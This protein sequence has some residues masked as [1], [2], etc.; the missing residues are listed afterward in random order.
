MTHEAN[1]PT[2]DREQQEQS[3]VKITKKVDLS[4]CV[5]ARLTIEVEVETEP[6]YERTAIERAAVAKAKRMAYA[7]SAWRLEEPVESIHVDDIYTTEED[8][9]STTWREKRPNE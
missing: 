1:G 8:R 5:L 2:D 3:R 7:L 4:G 6:A 9:L